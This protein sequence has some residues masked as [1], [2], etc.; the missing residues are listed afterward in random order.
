VAR[1]SEKYMNKFR[2]SNRGL[3]GEKVWRWATRRGAVRI[4]NRGLKGRSFN[5][6]NRLTNLK[7]RFES[8][9]RLDVP[10]SQG[11]V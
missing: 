2:I 9:N 5:C 11:E 10:K 6:P 1:W 4:S 7:K 8:G 3:K